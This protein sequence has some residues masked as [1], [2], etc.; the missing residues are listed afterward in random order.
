MVIDGKALADNLL[1]RLSGEISTLKTGG[2][3]PT[4]AV[5][6]AGDNPASAAYVRQ[7][8]KAAGKIGARVIINH[9][10][11][12]IHADKLRELIDMYNADPA[13][14]GLIIQRP[15]PATLGDVSTLLDSVN[16]RKDVDGFLPDSPYDVP[17]A[18]AVGEILRVVH[19]VHKL[20]A[21]FFHW[22]KTQ[23]IV[24]ARNVATWRS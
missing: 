18:L 6:L 24:V 12:T 3:T 16:P 22:L 9:Q 1:S 20:R 23:K 14:H 7:K 15:L 13:I 5:I 8:L 10:P 4:L 2:V 11:L 21:E 17:V 19:S